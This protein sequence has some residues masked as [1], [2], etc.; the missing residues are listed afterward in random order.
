MD[1]FAEVKKINRQQIKKDATVIRVEK[2]ELDKDPRKCSIIGT[3]MMNMDENG[4]PKKVKVQFHDPSGKSL[5]IQ[6]FADEG[7]MSNTLPGGMIRLDKFVTRADGSYVCGH[8]QRISKKDGPRTDKGGAQHYMAIDR[9]WTKIYPQLDDKGN[10][11][12]I[13]TATNEFSRGRALVIPEANPSIEITFNKDLGDQIKA[14]ATLA[15]ESAPDK[16]KAFL[17]FRQS[18][19]P[20]IAEMVIP[21]TKKNEAGNY[22]PITKAEQLAI[23]PELNFFKNM[24]KVNENPAVAGLVKE[25]VAGFQLDVYGMLN[26]PKSGKPLDKPRL[27]SMVQ[28]TQR[29]FSL[30]KKPG[31]ERPDMVAHNKPEFKL[32]V[33]SYEIPKADAATTA[34]LQ[35]LG[36]VPGVTA[37]P[38]AGLSVTPNPYYP[39][40]GASAAVDADVNAAV[41]TSEAAQASKAQQPAQAAPQQSAPAAAAPAPAPQP[42]QA[43]QD[44]DVDDAMLNQM[45]EDDYGFDMDDLEA[46]LSSQGL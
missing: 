11:A 17:M 20:T 33:I 37:S 23:V 30:P 45:G 8:M 32:A 38:N 14:A 18:D 43:D 3:D 42:D 21:N 24:M 40:P 29:N 39:A 27:K 22:V 4:V 34:S 31:Q 6:D 12:I 41:K 13:K 10:I 35:T 9:A 25:A 26:D 5:G 28:D 44:A 19:F 16:S 2:Y 1:V 7:S 15:I 36:S 46:Q